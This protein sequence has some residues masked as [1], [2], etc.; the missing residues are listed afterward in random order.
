MLT[1]LQSGELEARLKP[2]NEHDNTVVDLL[3][4]A[5]KRAPSSVAIALRDENITYADLAARCKRVA[6]SILEL[7][8]G[9]TVALFFPMMPEFIISFLGA[10]Y[11]KKCVLPLNLL[12]PPQE[13][14][15]IL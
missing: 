14:K 10:V 6:A 9:D 7:D 15:W 2:M 8:R 3:E 1:L 13:M 12:L 4:R 11:A 5:V